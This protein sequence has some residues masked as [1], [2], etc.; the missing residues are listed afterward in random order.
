AL[1]TTTASLH[2]E[3]QRHQTAIAAAAKER[4]QRQAQFDRELADLTA[5]RDQFA[6]RLNASET[7]LAQLRRDH[8]A[9]VADVERLTSHGA[10]LTSRLAD[11]TER[12]Q[13]VEQQLADANAALE[14]AV[15]REST[16]DDQLRQE[17][18][19]RTSVEQALAT[20]TT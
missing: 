17:H 20:T 11:T 6:Q 9:S 15:Q 16:L 1:G 4:T 3:Q 2:E 18:G 19:A 8:D 10:E 7:A 13:S 14:R 5:D 12:R